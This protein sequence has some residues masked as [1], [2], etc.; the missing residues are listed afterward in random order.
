[1]STT[2]TQTTPQVNGETSY[3]PKF[4]PKLTS[5]PVVDSVKKQIFLHVPQAENVSKYVGHQL[6]TAFSY[7]KDTP[8]QPILIKLDTLAADGVDKLEKEVP[9]VNTPTD[10]VLK[11]TKVDTLLGVVAHYYAIA[12]GFI[13]GFFDSTKAVA[14]PYINILLDRF[15][16]FLDIKEPEKDQKARILR[17]RSLIVEKV[18]AQVTPLLNKT[19]ETYT[20][21]YSSYIVP[22]A[23]Y[24]LEQFSATKD[25]AEEAYS[26]LLNEAK[27]RY[28]KAES[29][30][31]DAWNETKPDISGPNS[32]IPAAKAALFVAIA[33]AY[34][35]VYPEEKKP[36][37]K[38]EEQTN[39]LVSGVELNNSG[40]AKKRTNGP[41]S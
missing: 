38:T 28:A 23:K 1:M 13:A 40:S 19:K 17:I 24:P 4:L 39:G 35:L 31:K 30:A 6:S 11:N 21:L 15:E 29:S 37:S 14:D 36:V 20:S 2:T 27:S 41:T 22:L 16:G 10:E 9:I 7:T 3:S 26:P 18:D 32:A 12:T 34:K 25:K 33:F 5:I 8:I